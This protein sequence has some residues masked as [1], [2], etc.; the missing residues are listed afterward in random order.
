MAKRLIIGII[1][2]SLLGVACIIGAQL[3]YDGAVGGDYLF[4]FWLNRFLM[5]FVIALLPNCKVLWRL[6]IRGALVGLFIGFTFYSAT[7]YYDL[8]GFLVSA[9]YGIIIAFVLFKFDE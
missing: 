4:S 1:I 3:R 9:L 2:G 5:G 7:M 8:T 6:L